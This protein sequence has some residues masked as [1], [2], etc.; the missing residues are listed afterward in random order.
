MPLRRTV[1]LLVICAVPA[2][3]DDWPQW[4]GPKRDGGTT[5]KVA[6]WKE[7]LPVLWRAP[8]GHGF[9]TPAIADGRVFIHAR[10]GT[11]D[12]E[13]VV[14][15]DATTGKELWR[16]SYPRAPYKSAVG[17]GPRATPAVA[18]GRVYTFGITGVLSC[19]QADSGKRLWQADLYQ[20]LNASLPTF[21][22]CCSPLV[23]GNRVLVSVG[24]QGHSLVALDAETGEIKW[25][26]LDEG[27]SS[28][29][30][31]LFAGGPRGRGALPDVVFQTPL[32]LVGVNPLDGTLN[33]EHPM[34]FQPS[35]T[36]AT[37]VVCGDRIVA[38]TIDAGVTA[39]QVAADGEKVKT[40][41]EW[42]NKDYTVYFSSG[43]A[44]GF[45]QL[46]LVTNVTKP[47]PS[48]TLRCVDPKTGKEWW[49]KSGIGYFHAGL[50]RTGDD[51]LLILDDAGTLK[52]IDANPKEY[53]ELCQAKICSGTLIAPAIANGKL[54]ARDD[55]DVICV[56]LAE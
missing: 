33:W 26:A 16:D 51:K 14:A 1:L 10:V 28:S 11:K 56:K 17:V 45:D 35:G 29:S 18:G 31:V 9:S 30:P 43:L 4:Q 8:A 32:R 38:G 12:Q 7:A 15:F 23:L 2:P 48:A 44:V 55:K 21:G 20:K 19:Y 49:K 53:R 40:T 50:V 22:V 24:G 37:P 42:R 34:T 5:E 13:E 25:Q 46:Y 27:A 36:S 3:A 52:L 41:E 54:Y 39:V 6:P 47:L